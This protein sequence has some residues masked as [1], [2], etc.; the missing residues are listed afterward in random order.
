MGSCF[1][2]SLFLHSLCDL[3]RRCEKAG[4]ISGRSCFKS[5][6]NPMLVCSGWLGY[7]PIGIYGRNPRVVRLLEWSAVNG[8][9]LQYWR[10]HKQDRIWTGNLRSG[11][12]RFRANRNCLK[13]ARKLREKNHHAWFFFYAMTGGNPLFLSLLKTLVPL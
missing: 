8:C 13:I 4:R 11:R 2:Y 7:L 3:A 5:A 9:D 6:Q 12:K 10:R 1:R